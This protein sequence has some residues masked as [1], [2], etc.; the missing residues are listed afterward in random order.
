MRC[1]TPHAPSRSSPRDVHPNRAWL[2]QTSG[3][4]QTKQP[5]PV[6]F[7]SSLSFLDLR[8]H[9][10]THKRRNAAEV[11]I[12]I[13]MHP[14]IGKGW[15]EFASP[16]EISGGLDHNKRLQSGI[17]LEILWLRVVLTRQEH[18]VCI[19]LPCAVTGAWGLIQR[20]DIRNTSAKWKQE[21][22]ALQ[23]LILLMSQLCQ[24]ELVME[25]E[26]QKLPRV[27]QGS[28]TSCVA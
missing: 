1:Y 12:S 13:R 16:K 28:G 24:L 17:P 23:G 4:P 3:S 9:V 21:L 19:C 18:P 7:E 11:N 2:V 5:H 14:A 20:L 15:H 27:L 22:A 25:E 8:K 10:R 26:P 6:L